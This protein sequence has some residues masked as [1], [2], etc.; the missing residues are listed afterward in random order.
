MV[1]L[2]NRRCL[3]AW[4]SV[5]RLSEGRWRLGMTITAVCRNWLMAVSMLALLGCD[6]ASREDELMALAAQVS[7]T[8]WQ[9]LAQKRVFFG[10]QSV[11]YNILD[12]V[13]EIIPTQHQF[14]LNIAVAN[15][16]QDLAQ[17]TL[18]H[19]E[20]GHNT[21]PKSKIDDFVRLI[22]SG[23]GD[24]A[25]VVLLKFCYVDVSEDT[26]I[27][28][29][30]N[31]YKEMVENLKSKYPKTTFAHI[32]MPLVAKQEG[33]KIWAKNMAKRI[34]GRPIRNLTLNAKRGEFNEMLI[35][36]YEKN[37]PI[38][39]L[40]KIE[41]TTSNGQ[42]VIDYNDGLKFYSLS[43]SYT[44]DGGHLNGIG[45]KIVAQEFVRF[46]ASLPQKAK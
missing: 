14:Q 33:I 46:L 17:P 2:P 18:S 11:G 37:D 42:R 12:G 23:I 35:R 24:Q 31:E 38:F 40:A 28:K 7:T 45:R 41:S 27:A 16:P 20:V 34:L 3:A 43:P 1:R 13:K 25:D 5:Y 22:N 21:V 15:G 32:T 39:D 4:Q 44:D 36:E 6:E 19:A 8:E 30:F 29:L 26:D 10:H 9:A